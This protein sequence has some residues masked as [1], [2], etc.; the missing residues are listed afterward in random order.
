LEGVAPGDVIFA[1]FKVSGVPDT[2]PFTAIFIDEDQQT[3]I[4]KAQSQWKLGSGEQCTPVILKVP[5]GLRAA[6]AVLIIGPQNEV[7]VINPVKF[8]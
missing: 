1:Y 4:F 6:D 5:P 8:G 7:K 3:I 2:T